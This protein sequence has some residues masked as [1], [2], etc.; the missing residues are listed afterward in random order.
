MVHTA[1]RLLS[2][3]RVLRRV[4]E[5]SSEL[6]DRLDVRDSRNWD[7]ATATDLF[8]R[9]LLALTRMSPE[10]QLEVQKYRSYTLAMNADSRISHFIAIVDAFLGREGNGEVRTEDLA[11]AARQ[12]SYF[13][14][15]TSV[16]VGSHS[17]TS[18]TER[19]NS[20]QKLV[21]AVWKEG[22]V[23]KGSSGVEGG[24]R[25]VLVDEGSESQ[26]A[27]DVSSSY[28]GG[29]EEKGGCGREG[30]ERGGRQRDLYSAS[31]TL[32]GR[33]EEDGEDLGLGVEGE[34]SLP[35][36]FDPFLMF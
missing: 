26:S 22:G 5:V 16:G 3:E 36:L 33:R 34:R 30:G 13:Q 17:A 23:A 19:G 2:K 1:P 24:K 4:I 20:L 7:D 18:M 11:L 8:P 28:S 31:E 35:T 15:C 10:D 32:S 9:M 12:I 21:R 14:L 6:G 25:E 29:V 27:S